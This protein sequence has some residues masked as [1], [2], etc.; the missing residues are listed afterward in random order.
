MTLEFQVYEPEMEIFYAQGVGSKYTIAAILNK[1][2]QQK[3]DSFSTFVTMPYDAKAFKL[4]AKR[5][6]LN[7]LAVRVSA[8]F[9]SVFDGYG[10][11]ALAKIDSKRQKENEKLRTDMKK[12]Y[13]EARKRLEEKNR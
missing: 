3:N 4:R 9:V 6:N 12:S 7:P 1:N 5:G 8:Y 11:K 2:P 10:R 13:D